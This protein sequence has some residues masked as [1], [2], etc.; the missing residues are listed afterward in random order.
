MKKPTVE[1]Y[2]LAVCFVCIA[3]SAIFIMV[4]IYS[5]IEIAYPKFTLSAYEYRI[6][7]TDAS[8]LEE[9]LTHL[10]AERAG[11]YED[12]TPQE[13][14][15]ARNSGFQAAIDNERRRGRQGLL[16]S[17]IV[18]SILALIFALH[19]KLAGRTRR[20]KPAE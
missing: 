15:A 18:I 17:L 11:M 16:R 19:W 9:K 7:Q 3:F 13:L 12:M 6:Y 10:P 5:G 8:F 1:I 20:S 2:A 4:A 14:T